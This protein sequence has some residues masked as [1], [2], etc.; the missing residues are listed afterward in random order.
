MNN[1]V[2]KR[3]YPWSPPL[4]T[5]TDEWYY[6]HYVE[7]YTTPPFSHA[8]S[9]IPTLNIWDDHDIIDGYGSYTDKFMSCPV[10]RGL[11]RVAKKYYMLFQHHT[12]PV[13]ETPEDPNWILGGVNGRYFGDPSRSLY[14]RLGK[15]VAFVGVDARSERTRHMIN[16]LTT[17]SRIFERLDKELSDAGGEVKH[18]F[19]LLGI[20][21]AYPRLT[22]LGTILRSPFMGFIRFLNKRFGI[23]DSL[24]NGLD[25]SFDL[26]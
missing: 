19:V 15:R 11:G 22:W 17:Y 16:E 7:W 18:L 2:K 21:I 9:Q 24:F 10:F 5:D 4:S 23:A 8:T 20:P 13:G 14:A 1:P 6:N 25:G 26:L 12:P 3:S